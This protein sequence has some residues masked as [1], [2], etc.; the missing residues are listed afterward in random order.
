VAPEA[1][2]DLTDASVC[3]GVPNAGVVE[4]EDATGHHR[5][6]LQPHVVHAER[7]Q[8]PAAHRLPLRAS[9]PARVIHSLWGPFGV[10][11][12]EYRGKAPEA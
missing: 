10:L 2:P 1:G 4:A 5:L 11:S 3:H 9:S 8:R 6:G 12:H 7:T